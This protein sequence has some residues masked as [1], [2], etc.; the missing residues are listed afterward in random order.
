MNPDIE[1]G[2]LSQVDFGRALA[3]GEVI[4]ICTA[5]DLLRDMGI[6]LHTLIGLRL[7]SAL[8]KRIERPAFL[9]YRKGIRSWSIS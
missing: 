8:V 4:C 7:K 3:N 6:F 2:D 1:K 9:Y 5:N